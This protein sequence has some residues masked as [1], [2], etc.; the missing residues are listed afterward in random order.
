M[1]IKADN[2]ITS[3]SATRLDSIEPFPNQN[4]YFVFFKKKKPFSGPFI[5]GHVIHNSKYKISA[6]S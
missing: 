3:S 2:I 1:L 6:R 4:E 5:P